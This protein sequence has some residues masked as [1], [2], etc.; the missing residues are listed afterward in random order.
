[1]IVEGYILVVNDE[2]WNDD[3]INLGRG[4]TKYEVPTIKLF[5]KLEDA[6]T[7]EDAVQSNSDGDN[8]IETYKVTFEIPDP[9]PFEIKAKVEHVS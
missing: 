4:A 7:E 1:M 9:R 8:D 6:R 2:V 3:T 5:Q